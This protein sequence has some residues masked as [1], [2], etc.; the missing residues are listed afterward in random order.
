MHLSSS[1]DGIEQCLVIV[2][3]ISTNVW[4]A[5]ASHNGVA[6]GL[7]NL[8]S[9][10]GEPVSARKRVGFVDATIP[11]GDSSGIS[12]N[13]KVTLV[14]TEYNTYVFEPTNPSVT[15]RKL[16]TSL[17][18][19]GGDAMKLYLANF[20][21]WST[22]PHGP[23]VAS[24]QS[25][26][27]YAGFRPG[28]GVTFTGAIPTS[29]DVVPSDILTASRGG[30]VLQPWMLAWS[31]NS[32]PADVGAVR[33]LQTPNRER[34]TGLKVL[35]ENLYVF[36]PASIY[37]LTNAGDGLYARAY[38]IHRVVSGTG[39]IAPNSI[40]ENQGVLYFMA[41]DGI[42]AFGGLSAPGV[43]KVSAPIDAIFSH[44]FEQLA[45]PNT[46]ATKLGTLGYPFRANRGDLEYSEGLYVPS[47]KQ[48]WWS[49][50]VEGETSGTFSC[51]LVYD[52]IH[53]A[54]SVWSKTS[55]SGSCMVSGAVVQRRGQAD[56]VWCIDNAGYLSRFGFHRDTGSGEDYGVP[57]F[58]R[59]PRLKP[60]ER[61]DHTYVRTKL[62]M[63]GIGKTPSSLPPTITLTG[64]STPYDGGSTESTAALTTHPWSSGGTFTAATNPFLDGLGTLSAASG[65]YTSPDWFD[66]TTDGY[67]KSPSVRI[68][69]KDDPTT[70]ARGN[71]VCVRSI[72][73]LADAERDP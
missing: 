64:E 33:I 57:M 73:I 45:V 46:W 72:T 44:A 53:R 54:W 17:V 28:E 13:R 61:F 20:A 55:T 16:S 30:V 47:Q 6:I 66:S 37:V 34:V 56:I 9:L 11:I 39:C 41:S 31:D 70:F 18:T 1:A 5:A 50:P 8:T 69:V 48:I 10:Y 27:F 12:G 36:T 49:L 24:W 58:W 43:T 32:S 7:W 21:Y 71:L 59:T 67:I 25:Q 15:P 51:T 65:S 63:L 2:F 4:M 29:Q 3:T 40:V 22:P 14:S 19:A 52:L 68:G 60:S 23:I 35:G 42:Y 38:T 62:K 26:T